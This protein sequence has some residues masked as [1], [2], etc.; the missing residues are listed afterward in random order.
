MQIAI[1]ISPGCYL[2]DLTTI[3]DKI[4]I[5]KLTKAKIPNIIIASLSG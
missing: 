4:I 2:L 5:I 3:N 1:T